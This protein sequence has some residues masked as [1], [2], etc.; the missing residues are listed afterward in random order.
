VGFGVIE[1]MFREILENASGLKAGVD[2][3]LAY[4]PIRLPH[5]QTS[6]MV[7]SYERIVAAADKTSLDASATVLETLSGGRIRKTNNLKAAEM[8]VLFET[9]K[10][11]VNT[12]LVNELAL[13]CEKAGIDYLETQKLAD[14][15]TSNMLF[16]P[17]LAEESD[18][19][20]P[21]L[22]LEN[23]ENLN[24]KLRIVSSVRE[25][26]EE[27]IRHAADLTKD[28]LR[29]CEKTMTRARVSLLGISQIPNEKSLPK[30][31]VKELAK[32]LE[33]KGVRVSFYDPH[34]SENEVGELQPHF[35]KSLTEAVEGA[36]C[37]MIIT[38]HDQFKRL[39][40]KKLK[41]MMKMPAA[42][43]D[44]EGILEPDK[45]EE[46]GFIYRGLGRGVWTK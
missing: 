1:G 46:E 42:I 16:S 4:S 38:G 10:Q 39:N 45:V 28:A 31:A 27:I 19:E 37:I 17:T 41:V 9:T 18:Q 6:E 34:F 26:N 22:L 8:G 35:K 33:T 44:L 20:E 25:I 21:Y 3:G 36:D 14:P 29:N 7:A 5:R 43:V 11:N 13:L 32:T 24:S 23:A 15:N 40:L 12:A 2:F 30:R